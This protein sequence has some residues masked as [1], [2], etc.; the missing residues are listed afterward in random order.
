MIRFHLPGRPLGDPILG[1][2]ALT[3]GALIVASAASLVPTSRRLGAGTVTLAPCDA[4]GFAYR[5]AIDTSGQIV[6]VT[7]DSIAA[8]CAGGTLRVTLANS[9]S[10]AIGS[11][12]VALPSTSFS[13]TVTVALSP[14]PQSSLV[15]S[16]YAAIEGP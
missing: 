11:G 14:T 1:L 2:A 9:A 6:N 12:A 7:V 3:L 15:A 16:T 13:G 8:A 10:A 5:Y 4:N